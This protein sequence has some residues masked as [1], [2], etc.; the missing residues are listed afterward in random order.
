MIR[1]LKYVEHILD[2]AENI[3]DKAES[4]TGFFQKTAG[5]MA[6]GKLIA[7]IVDSMKSKEKK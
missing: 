2:K 7:N 4:I 6:V 1:I 3:A 5:P